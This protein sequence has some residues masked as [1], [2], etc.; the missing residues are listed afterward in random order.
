MRKLVKEA[1]DREG[2][3]MPYPHA[4]EMSKGEVA[5]RTPPIKPAPTR[6]SAA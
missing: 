2:I 4:V 6:R 1:F 3:E 5:A